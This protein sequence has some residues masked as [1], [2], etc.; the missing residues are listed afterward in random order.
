[1]TY[2]E[3]IL[4]DEYTQLAYDAQRGFPQRASVTFGSHTYICILAVVVP[5]L[6]AVLGREP[7]DLL[8]D[9]R[10]QAAERPKTIPSSSAHLWN[11]DDI[12]VL[13]AMALRPYLLVRESNTLLASVPLRVGV[14]VS[15]GSVSSGLRLEAYVASCKIAA[16]SLVRAGEFGSSLLVGIRDKTLG[17]ERFETVADT[18]TQEDVYVDLF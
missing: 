4:P 16:G 10:A 5:D 9:L 7:T 1:M 8:I 17:V 2:S 6:P 13:S 18:S 3:S 15:I 11:H 14:P 12:H